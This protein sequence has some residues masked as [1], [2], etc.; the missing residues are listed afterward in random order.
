M[1]LKL[2]QTL[3]VFKRRVTQDLTEMLQWPRIDQYFCLD[4]FQYFLELGRSV[5]CSQSCI[6]EI[7]VSNFDQA[8][9]HNFFVFGLVTRC[10]RHLQQSAPKD[11]NS[12]RLLP[13]KHVQLVDSYSLYLVVA[14]DE[15][16]HH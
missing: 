6:Q 8:C 7:K 12:V 10:Y 9:F 4:L 2:V 5:E 16:H 3:T 14:W 13:D 11:V 15:L 1:D